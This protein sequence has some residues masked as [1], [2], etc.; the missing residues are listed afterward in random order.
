MKIEIVK[1]K[2][3]CF[4]GH[5]T[6]KLLKNNPTKEVVILREVENKVIELIEQGYDT[7]ITGGAEGFDRLCFYLINNLKRYFPHIKNIVAIPYCEYDLE[8]K[9]KGVINYTK[10]L[11]I[12]DEVIYVDTEEGYTS[13]LVPTGKYAKFKLFDRNKFMVD[14]SNFIIGAWDGSNSGTKH[15]INYARSKNID[16]YVINPD[17][18]K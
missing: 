9:N 2:T 5:R 8:Y 18:Y 3:V 16:G 17:E 4:T 11:N 1:E 10:M 6:Y 14:Y 7:F 13:K 12:A 15:A